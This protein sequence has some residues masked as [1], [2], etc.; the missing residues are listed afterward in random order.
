MGP[1]QSDTL[2]AVHKQ[3][4]GLQTLLEYQVNF[5]KLQ[6]A[7]V[8]QNGVRLGESQITEALDC[9]GHHCTV[10]SH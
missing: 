8:P 4:I 5:R 3:V 10:K 2:W 7:N 1:Q 9:R 6:L